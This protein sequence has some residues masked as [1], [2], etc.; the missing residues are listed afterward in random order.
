MNGAVFELR[1]GVLIEQATA[2]V[3]GAISVEGGADEDG[4]ADP[5]LHCSAIEGGVAAEDTAVEGGLRVIS[6]THCAASEVCIVG[7]KRTVQEGG[8]CGQVRDCS[9]RACGVI[10]HE[11]A[12][13]NLEA[14]E[15]LAE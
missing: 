5:I 13:D 12:V 15:V 3:C 9:S 7:R 2:I 1:I 8:A 14:G 11:V 4:I 10:V 6:I